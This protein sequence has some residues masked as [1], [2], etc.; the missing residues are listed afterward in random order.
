MV[1][2]SSLDDDGPVAPP[3]PRVGMPPPAAPARAGMRKM[4]RMRETMPATPDSVRVTL[5]ATT[6]VA[7]EATTQ[8]AAGVLE[9]IV[10][11][12]VEAARMTTAVP[13]TIRA[14]SVVAVD[15]TP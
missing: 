14:V 12:P 8:V 4:P 2:S 11:P 15:V 5:A 9:T 10:T 6:R 1:V 13:E 3:S 7:P